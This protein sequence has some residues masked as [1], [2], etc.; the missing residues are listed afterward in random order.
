MENKK[1]RVT[2]GVTIEVNDN[3]DTIV[4]RID[5]ALFVNGF[6]DLL[7]S[8]EKTQ[9]E[10]ES[11]TSGTEPSAMSDREKLDF[12]TEKTKDIMAQIDILFGVDTCEKVFCGAIPSAYA[13]ADFFDQLVPIFEEYADK[14]Q[15][16]IAE[17]YNRSRKGS[18]PKYNGKPQ[19]FGKGKK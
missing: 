2:T 18:K 4:A 8:M 13:I 1:L 5:D 12:I 16:K 10:I 15:K 19:Y 11:A 14:R 6:Y 17:K 7:D 9:N 3:G